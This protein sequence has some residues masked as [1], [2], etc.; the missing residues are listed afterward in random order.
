[1][2][3]TIVTTPAAQVLHVSAGSVLTFVGGAG[4]PI[5]LLF[6]Y[7][8]W[9]RK[10]MGPVR[11]ILD[12]GALLMALTAGVVLAGYWPGQWAHSLF[13]KLAAAWNKPPDRTGGEEW[14]TV[15][16]V[17]IVCF[18]LGA[19]IKV[20]KREH[21]GPLTGVLVMMALV[22]VLLM[23]TQGTFGKDTMQVVTILAHPTAFRSW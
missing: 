15:V 8:Q 4:I 5:A 2:I 16:A 13:G 18:L 7:H 6:G 9:L 1:M 22:P 21:Q 10:H 23:A 12:L 3:H 17:L 19:I 20:A 11:H 14:A